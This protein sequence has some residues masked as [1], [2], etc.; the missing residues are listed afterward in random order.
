MVLEKTLESPL[1]CKEIQPVHPK[2]D[3]PWIFTGRTDADAEAPIL[4]HLVRRTESFEKTLMLGKIEGRRRRGPPRMRWLDPSCTWCIWVWVS[5]GMVMDK[6]AWHA[7][8]L[9]SMVLQRVGHAERLS[10]IEAVLVSLHPYIL[11]CVELD[12]PKTIKLLFDP[13]FFSFSVSPFL[14]SRRWNNYLLEPWI[15]LKC[16]FWCSRSGM[17]PESQ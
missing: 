5:S 14:I 11:G 9:Q 3:Q 15:S 8:R 12:F 10:S 13:V 16:R 7:S 2:G 6:E 1:D 4:W 17:L